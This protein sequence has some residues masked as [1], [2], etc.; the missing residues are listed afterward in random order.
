MFNKS[1]LAAQHGTFSFENLWL[2][3]CF[4]VLSKNEKLKNMIKAYG[5]FFYLQTLL[6][7]VP[8]KKQFLNLR[9]QNLK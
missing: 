2:L 8:K 5:V 9:D 6:F 1:R 7:R 3:L 4:Q